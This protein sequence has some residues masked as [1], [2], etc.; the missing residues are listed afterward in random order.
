MFGLLPLVAEVN[1]MWFALP[2]VAVISL[3]YSATHHEA[4]RP[5]LTHSARLA[6]MIIGFMLAI[7]IVLAIIGWSL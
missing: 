3:V 5:I 7:M 4:M 6:V 2:L 1:L